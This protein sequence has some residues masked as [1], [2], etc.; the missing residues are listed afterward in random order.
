VTSREEATA[1][2]RAAFGD[3]PRPAVLLHPQ[4]ADDTDL[5]V[6]AAKGHWSELTW[7]EVEGSYAALSFLSAE[8][9]A[10]FVPAF[11][12]GVLE[13]PDSD[14]AVVDSTVWAFLPSLYSEDLRP[15]V[16]SHWAA[17]DHRQRDAVTLFLAAMQPHH[18]DAGR[19]GGEWTAEPDG[20]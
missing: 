12:L 17:L 10:H 11:L 18:P 7:D 19:A 13:H 4:C 1:A 3:V 16:R 20:T 6:L 5:E 2:I 9:F 14:A 8:G 15:F